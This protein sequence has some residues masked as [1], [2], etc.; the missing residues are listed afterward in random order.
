MTMPCG[1]SKP[2]TCWCRI[3]VSRHR[4]A[5]DHHLGCLPINGVN[6]L[7]EGCT[8]PRA[9]YSNFLHNKP[10]QIRGVDSRT[11]HSCIVSQLAFSYPQTTAR[12]STTVD[13]PTTLEHYRW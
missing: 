12:L 8:C 4:T 9:A 6:G 13:H 10:V 1:S 3:R 2:S 11:Q 5:A 7:D